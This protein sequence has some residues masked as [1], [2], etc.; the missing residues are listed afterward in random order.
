MGRP[1][2]PASTWTTRSWRSTISACAPTSWVSRLDQYK[3][4]DRVTLLVARREQLTADR[5]GARRRAGAVSGG[6]RS[7]PPLTD[8]A[9]AAARPVAQA[10]DMNVRSAVRRPRSQRKLRGRQGALPVAADGDSP[11]APGDARR[12]RHRHRSGRPHP[13]RRARLHLDERR[14]GDALRRPLRGPVLSTS[15]GCSSRRAARK[16][17]AGCTPRAAATTST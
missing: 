1:P 7:N 16:R 14:P 6:S 10:A 13:A 11:R 2:R 5:A 8:D 17:P 3:P 12:P 4:G 15:S 9:A